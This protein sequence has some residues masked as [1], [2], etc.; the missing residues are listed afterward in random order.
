MNY[1]VSFDGYGDG[2]E[3]AIS[4]SCLIHYPFFIQSKCSWI[5]IR[6]LVGLLLHIQFFQ[7]NLQFNRV[8]HYF[9][10]SFGWMLVVLHTILST[11]GEFSVHAWHHRGGFNTGYS[12]WVLWQPKLTSTPLHMPKRVWHSTDQYNRLCFV[13]T[14]HIT[15]T[16]SIYQKLTK[17]GKS[18][19]V[20]KTTT[21]IQPRI[22]S[23]GQ[24]SC[25]SWLRIT[26]LLN[27][28]L[29]TPNS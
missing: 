8:L 23:N 6:Q 21:R 28:Y 29:F 13:Q 25:A 10:R 18:S 27:S 2:W 11:F 26:P 22:R 16:P 9:N 24:I 14:L 19:I 5:Q 7:T 20:C 17:H 4:I 15:S 3:Q 1:L 12:K